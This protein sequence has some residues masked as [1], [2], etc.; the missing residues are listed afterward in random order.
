MT[1]KQHLNYTTI[2]ILVFLA[3]NENLIIVQVIFCAFFLFRLYSGVPD[4]FNKDG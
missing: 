2:E 3:G 1:S 4:L